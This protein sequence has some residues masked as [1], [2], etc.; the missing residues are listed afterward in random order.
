M[1]STKRAT[2]TITQGWTA[3]PNQPAHLNNNAGVDTPNVATF[4]STAAVG[5]QNEYGGFDFS[6]IP[7]GSQ[8]N[9]I[10][11]RQLVQNAAGDAATPGMRYALKISGAERVVATFDV[12]TEDQVATVIPVFD[13]GSLTCAELRAGLLSVNKRTTAARPG[14]D[15]PIYTE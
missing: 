10:T 5:Q 14:V 8:I 4:N 7:V 6:D 3:T 2:T 9:S 11:I 1:I 12:D 13:P 15:P